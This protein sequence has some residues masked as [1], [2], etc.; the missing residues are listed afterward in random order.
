MRQLN[1]VVLALLWLTLGLAK[2]LQPG[3]LQSYLVLEHEFAESTA[4]AITWGV[5]ALEF[6]MGVLLLLPQ[7]PALQQAVPSLRRTT[8]I[9]S[10]L[11]ALG[12][13]LYILTHQKPATPCGCFG[14]LGEATHGRRLLLVGMLILLGAGAMLRESSVMSRASTPGA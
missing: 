1:R 11:A 5:V 6:T 2:A 12:F 9:L 3:E 7:V 4:V 10:T 8:L 13:L 14:A